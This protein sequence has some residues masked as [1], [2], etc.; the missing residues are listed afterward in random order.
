[1]A[2]IAEDKHCLFCGESIKGRA[3]K[4]FCD[5]QCRTSFNNRL[6]ND[7]NFMRNVNNA[8]RKNRR[9]IQEIVDNT[10]DGKGK[11]SG[12]KL[13]DK[14]FTFSY[15]THTYTTKT[16]SVY[17]FCYEY[18]YLKLENDYYMLVKRNEP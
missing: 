5:D 10:E 4:K 12:K 14:G 18:G 2:I 9:I 7:S 3:D 15:Y 13:L 11:A 16:G 6:K 8:L 17:H 1:M